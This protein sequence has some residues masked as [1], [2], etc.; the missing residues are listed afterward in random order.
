MEVGKVSGT[1]GHG[2]F[3]A[4]R[5]HRNMLVRSGP[6]CWDGT[7]V[8]SPS[9]KVKTNC[10]RSWVAADFLQFQMVG[11]NSDAQRS[12][13]PYGSRRMPKA[14]TSSAKPTERERSVIVVS[15][16]RFAGR[17]C[18]PARRK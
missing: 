3:S 18:T 13:S 10:R 7:P 15:E 6:M 17:M 16:C 5:Y 12:P 11:R 14:E 2:S 9:E 1:G 8:R 4:H